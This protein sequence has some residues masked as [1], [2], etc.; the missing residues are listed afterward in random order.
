[1]KEIM[2]MPSYAIKE[3]PKPNSNVYNLLDKFSLY[4]DKPDSELNSD[5][6]LEKE[7]LNDVFKTLEGKD[8]LISLW[9]NLEKE[10]LISRND[11]LFAACLIGASNIIGPDFKEIKE[12]INR[13]TINLEVAKNEVESTDLS[14]TVKD[15]FINIINRLND[16]WHDLEIKEKI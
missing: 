9:E 15:Y 7:S 2:F 8:S 5:E 10:G 11:K 3:V 16:Y 1:M 4:I 14:L 6:W 13:K 12:M